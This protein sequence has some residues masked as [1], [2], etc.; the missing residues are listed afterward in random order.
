MPE[1]SASPNGR[2]SEPPTVLPTGA[3]PTEAIATWMIE[4]YSKGYTSRPGGGSTSKLVRI[5]TPCGS[6]LKRPQNAPIKGCEAVGRVRSNLR[7]IRIFR[8]R[9]C[10]VS[11]KPMPESPVAQGAL[12][13]P[14]LNAE[15]C[16]TTGPQMTNLMTDVAKSEPTSVEKCRVATRRPARNDKARMR[17]AISLTLLVIIGCG[18]RI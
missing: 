9:S 7:C 11:S 4:A 15:L 6:L 8:Q 17:R 18:D 2:T 14:F 13:G 12:Q 16:E 1:S 10:E 3:L 5:G